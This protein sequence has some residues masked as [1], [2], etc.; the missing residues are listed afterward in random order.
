MGTAARAIS[1]F[2]TSAY[3][4]FKHLTRLLAW[5]YFTVFSRHGSFKL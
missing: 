2:K 4:P 1:V 5:K 3:S